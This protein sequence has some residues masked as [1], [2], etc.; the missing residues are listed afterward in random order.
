[1]ASNCTLG[2]QNL[3][4]TTLNNKPWFEYD[5]SLGIVNILDSFA[6]KINKENS[7]G[8]AKTTAITINKQINDG[9]KNIG[10]I[11][12]VK[13]NKEGRGY[14]DIAPSINQI[15]LIN[16]QNAKEINEL[17][18][19]LD[20][21]ELL[22]GFYQTRET[23]NY[24]VVDGEIV[25]STNNGFNNEY[26]LNNFQE[27]Q[28]ELDKIVTKINNESK[29]L[30][31]FE[32]F[33]NI[34]TNENK[35]TSIDTTKSDG[36]LWGKMS[37]Y[38]SE[39]NFQPTES[40]SQYRSDNSLQEKINGRSFKEIWNSNE[41]T[42]LERENILLHSIQERMLD[43]TT[44]NGELF[45][46]INSKLGKLELRVVD[47]EKYPFLAFQKQIYIN[48]K[49]FLKYLQNANIE[50]VDKYLDLTVSEELI[51]VLT[52]YFTSLEDIKKIATEINPNNF[53]YIQSIYKSL[54][55]G[56]F[57]LGTREYLR[58]IVQQEI[59]GT[60]TEKIKYTKNGVIDSIIDKIWNFLYQIFKDNKGTLAENVKKHID[61]IKSNNVDS[62]NNYKPDIFQVETSLSQNIKYQLSKEQSNAI[63]NVFDENPEL[64]NSVYSALGFVPKMITRE[65]QEY[66]NNPRIRFF[67]K[68]ADE[69]R[70]S[71]PKIED[72]YTRLY[73]GNR[74]SDLK[75]NPQFTNSLEGIALPFL[76]S[77]EG[78]LSYIDI[79]TSDL[80]KYVQKGGVATNAE[81]IVTP[82]IAKTAT[83][84]DNTIVEKYK[85]QY[86]DKFAPVEITPQQKQQARQLYSQYLEQNPNGSIE[87]FKSW[88]D[89][90]NRNK[91]NLEQQSENKTIY[92]IYKEKPYLKDFIDSTTDE[93]GNISIYK[94]KNT[95]DKY[96][97][98]RIVKLNKILYNAI[99]RLWD[100]NV[101]AQNNIKIKFVDSLPENAVGNFN[102]DNNEI[103]I[104]KRKFLNNVINN[105]KNYP[106]FYLGYILNH[107]IIHYLTPKDL[108]LKIEYI[109]RALNDKF[110][111][112]FRLEHEREFGKNIKELYDV[113]IQKLDN[114]EDYGFLNLAEFVA[115]AM[116][117]PS[118]Q[119]KLASIPFKSSK[120]SLWKRF[121]EILSAYL[122][123]YTKKPITDTLLEAV[124][125]ETTNYITE[126]S[127][128]QRTYKRKKSGKTENIDI[129]YD[130]VY[131]TQKNI[132]SLSDFIAQKSQQ[133]LN[134]IQ[135]V[136]N[137]NPELSKIGTVE[138]YSQ[139]LDT[140]FPDSKVKEIDNSLYI[141]VLNQLEQ[142]DKIEKDCKGKLK[143]KDGI[144]TLFE[145]GGKWEIVT[146]FKN[147]PTHKSG[148]KDVSIQGKKVEV[149]KNELRIENDF[150]D[151]AVIPSKYRIEVQDAIKSNCHSCIDGIVESLP[152][153]KD[154]AGD[155]TVFPFFGRYK[156]FKNSL[157]D[158]LKNTPEDDY[159]MRYYWKHSNKPKSFDEAINREQ[160]MFTM[161]DDGYYHAPSVEPNTLRF[162]KPKNHPTLQYELDW[163]NSDNPDAVD[164]KSKYD[165]DTSGKFYRYKLKKK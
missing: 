64:A 92:E 78:Q 38:E 31:L 93:S 17:Q 49:T 58:M 18:K 73:R 14:I 106:I 4:K 35:P 20:E 3:V 65:G 46:G 48:P 158:N 45:A 162:L 54:P 76:M 126:N 147:A 101:F 11:A 152:K 96:G 47:N 105:D 110:G 129:G 83:P 123:L 112:T 68:I 85:E 111:D 66:F 77:Y 86:P 156:K 16:A 122:S 21:E 135:E 51:H 141:S 67:V 80:L 23:G 128:I 81:F 160:P 133:K 10:D 55:S 121:I 8:V 60:T 97:E 42:Q 75:S 103:T 134:Q 119:E 144:A 89:E 25:V 104:D 71:L 136:F 95:L 90:F 82:E 139:Y 59:L 117:N 165:L 130:F 28:K 91:S 29:Q 5:Q 118:F 125:A 52:N 163:Y 2:I 32:S 145:K 150:G 87:E 61:F 19:Q 6:K 37:S 40:K 100:N 124:I 74:P 1:M 115:E 50:D 12:F 102:R 36:L 138:Q 132:N 120:Q 113:A 109:D 84:I 70:A 7:H 146:D 69:V 63:N 164:F 148:G 159:A 57:E 153:M 30:D 62:T 44:F 88:V 39:T 34:I 155:G 13:S 131:T 22:K 140:I 137:E 127:N 94:V 161:E 98:G 15:Y 56:D 43:K 9:Y 26:S 108:S 114:T 33:Q 24:D 99:Y 107:E 53:K 157:P 79:P 154:Y 27:E 143:A 72:G 149:E 151:V 41:F 116:S 142:E